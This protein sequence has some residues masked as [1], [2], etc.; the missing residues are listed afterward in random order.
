M[1]AGHILGSSRLMFLS[2]INKA[3]KPGFIS[4][5]FFPEA[6]CRINAFFPLEKIL[7]VTIAIIIPSPSENYYCYLLWQPRFLSCHKETEG[8][9]RL[10]VYKRLT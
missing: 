3:D 5:L 9:H 2:K 1:A 7:L 4:S 8:R 10:E 6:E